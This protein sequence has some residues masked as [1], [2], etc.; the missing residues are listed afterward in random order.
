[1]CFQKGPYI[2][3][4]NTETPWRLEISSGQELLCGSYFDESFESFWFSAT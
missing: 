4:H 3:D 2:S 1:M